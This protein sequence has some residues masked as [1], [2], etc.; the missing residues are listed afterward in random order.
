MK[1]KIYTA[2]LFILMLLGI[3]F[4]NTCKQE[5]DGAPAG[6]CPNPDTSYC[7]LY[8]DDLAKIPYHTHD[9]IKL[10]S[11]SGGIIYT[12]ISKT[13]DTSYALFQQPPQGCPG[14]FQKWQSITREFIS[15]AYQYP[16]IE[17]QYLTGCTGSNT[18]IYFD[19]NMMRIYTT[20][21]GWPYYYDSIVINQIK[22]FNVDKITKQYDTTQYALFNSTEGVLEIVSGGK[23]WKRVP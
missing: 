4:L 21:I 2:L 20:S 12:F 19:K 13:A 22:Y 17:S 15:P 3:V 23:I 8:P 14:N 6:P 7:Y 10:Q 1:T 11:D 18:A 16:L 5:P 9:T